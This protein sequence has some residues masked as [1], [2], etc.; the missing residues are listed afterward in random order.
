M[1]S[2]HDCRTGQDVWQFALSR[3]ESVSG[4]DVHAVVGAPVD[5]VW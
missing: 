4:T 5:I 2:N 1:V 3:H